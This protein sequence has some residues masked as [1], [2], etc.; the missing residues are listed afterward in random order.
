YAGPQR[1][2]PG[3][4]AATPD[5]AAVRK[6]CLTEPLPAGLPIS[7]TCVSD[8]LDAKEFD[9][10]FTL[11]AARFRTIQRNSDGSL[12]VDYD[13]DGGDTIRL[14]GKRFGGD[15]AHGTRFAAA[16]RVARGP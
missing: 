5:A 15:P 14:G 8:I 13:G 16:Y 1:P 11:D 4:P 6:I 10:A 3:L 2:R 7:W 12:Q 9:R